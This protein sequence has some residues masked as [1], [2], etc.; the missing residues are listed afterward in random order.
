L[1]YLIV[2]VTSGVVLS[3]PH[4]EVED[5]HKGTNG[6]WIASEHDIAETNTVVGCN[7]ASCHSCEGQLRE[8]Q[9][10]ISVSSGQVEAYLLIQLDILHHFEAKGEVSKVHMD[11]QKANNAEVTEHS[12]QGT[13][14]IFANDFTAHE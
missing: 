7:M 12:V 14:S 8:G 5:C 13:L 1:N 3:H 10:L 4:D 9:Y 2:L 6:I 11:S